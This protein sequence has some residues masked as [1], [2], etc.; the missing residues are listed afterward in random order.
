MYTRK[1]G[2][3]EQRIKKGKKET[4]DVLK[5]LIWNVRDA[6]RKEGKKKD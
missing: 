6:E 5:V 1:I 2:D 4:S 3:K